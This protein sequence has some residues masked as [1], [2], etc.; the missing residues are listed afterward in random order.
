VH[1][2][3]A[4]RRAGRNAR[5]NAHTRGQVV[6]HESPTEGALAKLP[7]PAVVVLDP[8]R[9]GAGQQVMAHLTQW[10]PRRIVYVA[11]DPA[12]LA[13]DLGYARS[14]GYEATSLTGYDLFCHTHHVE[15]VAVLE[16]GA[17][18]ASHSAVR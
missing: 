7:R 10:R 12:A 8:P 13:R 2:V 9:T 18:V 3:E 5:R 1:A 17:S 11:C 16:P 4:D 15:C 6:L 14:E